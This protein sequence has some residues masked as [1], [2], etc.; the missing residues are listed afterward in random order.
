MQLYNLVVAKGDPRLLTREDV[1]ALEAQ[2]GVPL[3]TALADEVKPIYGAFVEAII[4]VGDEPLT[5]VY[6]RVLGCDS[7][8][9]YEGC[10][11]CEFV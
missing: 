2:V 10:V 7:F 1:A 5:Y 6:C 9:E 4:P 8:C 3:G 11:D